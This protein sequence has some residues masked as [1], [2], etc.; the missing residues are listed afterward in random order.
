MD[1]FT[2]YELLYNWPLLH[3]VRVLEKDSIY[4]ARN[5]VNNK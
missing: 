4:E 1:Y 2:V 5:A 3:V